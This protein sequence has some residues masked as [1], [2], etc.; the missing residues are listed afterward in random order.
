MYM[1]PHVM[2]EFDNRYF[3]LIKENLIG[4]QKTC[5]DYVPQQTIFF[6]IT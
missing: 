1:P 3:F 5:K 6:I 2:S 4:F